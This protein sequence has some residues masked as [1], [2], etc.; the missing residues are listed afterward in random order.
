MRLNREQN[1]L[2]ILF[3]N[4]ETGITE[5]VMNESAKKLA[6]HSRPFLFLEN[7]N[8]IF[9]S[10]R[11]NYLHFYLYDYKTKTAK[12]ITKRKLGS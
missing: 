2:E 9:S 4:V 8:F 12:Q 1:N 5:V 3:S 11:D 10:E 6:R 7:G